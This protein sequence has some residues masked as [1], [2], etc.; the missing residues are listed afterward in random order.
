VL[1]GGSVN[2][3][4]EDYEASTKLTVTPRV[5]MGDDINL[6]ITQ[7]INEIIGYNADNRPLKNE[8]EITTKITLDDLQTVVM[9][10]FI[11]NSSSEFREKIP[12]LSEIPLIGHLF[13]RKEIVN[14]KNELVV[15]ITPR[16]INT[17]LESD[18]V[19]DLLKNRLTFKQELEILLENMKRTTPKKADNIE[20]FVNENDK[21][22]YYTS[23]DK[24]GVPILKD[25]PSKLSSGI[26]FTKEITSQ[27]TPHQA[28]FGYGPIRMQEYIYNTELKPNN[29]YAFIHT[30]TVENP[31]HYQFVDLRVA[32]DKAAVVYINGEIV[33]RD[34]YINTVSGHDFEYWNREIRLQPTIL[35]KGNNEVFAILKNDTTSEDAFF[36]LKLKGI[37]KPSIVDQQARTKKKSVANSHLFGLFRRN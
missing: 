6:S 14:E 15:F 7:T 2:Y 19:R 26:L 9:G 11:Q 18:E 35:K 8:R 36:D 13:N 25:S 12:V 23:N 31:E 5:S 20:I 16:I 27:L 10:G 24:T 33:D 32:S 34:P 4:T 21:N 22:W 28:P 30:F 37:I 29:S 3:T 1:K 17:T